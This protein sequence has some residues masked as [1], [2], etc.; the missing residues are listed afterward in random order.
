MNKLAL[1][2]PKVTKLPIPKRVQLKANQLLFKAEEHS[3]ELLLAGGI[4][5]GVGA[6]VMAC[7]A[8]LKVEGVLDVYHKNLE[9]I[10]MVMDPENREKFENY[11][12]EDAK[13]DKFVNFIQTIGKLGKLYA[14]AIGL[15]IMSVSCLLGSYRIMNQR[16]IAL[17]AAYLAVKK[18]YDDYR[19]RVKEEIGE[20]AE[21]D[22]FHGVKKITSEEVVKNKKGDEKVVKKEGLVRNGSG[23]SPYARFFDESSVY[24]R[25]DQG[26]NKLFLIQTQSQMNDLLK[27]R[28]H[29]FLNEVYDALD[30]P[31]SKEGAVVGWKLGNGDNYI[32]FGI[33]DPYKEGARRFVNEFER[34]IL[35]DFNVDGVIYDII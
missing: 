29:V 1:R 7:K 17:N 33:W 14:P 13:R 27:L 26:L 6:T 9:N 34:A 18:A 35:L 20:E 23:Y 4:I 2:L 3:P 21:D 24:F 12:D 28:G 10:T 19:E 11:T 32:D 16:Q 15:G 8:T 25:K 30:I 31:H 22:L 5:L